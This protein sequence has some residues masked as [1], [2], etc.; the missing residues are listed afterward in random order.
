MATESTDRPV[1]DRQHSSSATTS[2]RRFL[3]QSTGL[4]AAAGLAPLFVPRHVLGGE[5]QQAPSDTLRIAALGIGGMGQNYLEGCR[6]ERVVALCDLDHQLSA[7]VFEKY[8]DAT[9][10]HDF[11]EMFDREADNFDALIIGTPDHTHT[12]ILMAALQLGKHIYC[13]K[14]ITHSISEARR[15]RDAVTKARH[16]VTKSSVQS[17]GTEGSRCTTELLNSGVIGPVREL[18]IWCD[19][20][21]YPCSVV[22]PTEQQTPPP[23]MD[24]DLWIGPAPYRPYHSAYHPWK[25]LGNSRPVENCHPCRCIGTTEECSPV[26]RWNWIGA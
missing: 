3:T 20:P 25:S 14:P 1:G 17:S 12:V 26:A 9:R 6:G 10:Y 18:H 16:L 4:A 21:V 11:R 7:K 8:P 2:R 5:G 24:W 15:V 23:G 22:R 19:H 13:A